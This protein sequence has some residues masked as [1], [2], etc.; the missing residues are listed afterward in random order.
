MMKV[1]WGSISS[2][3]TVLRIDSKAILFIL[4]SERKEVHGC[5]GGQVL[6][7]LDVGLQEDREGQFD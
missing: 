2:W 5:V 1:R 4:L 3:P 7:V 6:H